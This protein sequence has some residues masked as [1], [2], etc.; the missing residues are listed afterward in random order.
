MKKNEKK[1]GI[2]V[3]FTDNT[4]KFSKVFKQ[5]IF[6]YFLLDLAEITPIL[7]SHVKYLDISNL[8]INTSAKA[9]KF[10]INS[11]LIANG[12]Y[13]SGWRIDDCYLEKSSLV[14]VIDYYERYN[15]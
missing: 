4:D 5:N 11:L 15:I 10:L 9:I 7:L 12:L 13:K 8:D 3:R 14:L 2:D 6:L 1:Y